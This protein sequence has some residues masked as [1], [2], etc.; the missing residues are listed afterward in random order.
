LA[1]R[2]ARETGMRAAEA[3]EILRGSRINCETASQQRVV[4][5]F[6]TALAL[7]VSHGSLRLER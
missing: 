1:A 7:K 3:A 2:V 6:R 5:L 4:A